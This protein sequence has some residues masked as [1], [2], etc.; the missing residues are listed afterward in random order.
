[1]VGAGSADDTVER[2]LTR[3]FP[4]GLCGGT[5]TG[6]AGDGGLLSEEARMDSGSS[7][8]DMS[9]MVVAGDRSGGFSND[10]GSRFGAWWLVSRYWRGKRI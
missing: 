4:V 8:S 7:P 2:V 6:A 3:E 9:S 10:G 1:M 5:G